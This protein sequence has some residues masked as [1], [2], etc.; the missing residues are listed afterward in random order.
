MRLAKDTVGSIRQECMLLHDGKKRSACLKSTRSCESLNR[1][2][3]MIELAQSESEV[4]VRQQDFDTNP[5]NFACNNG[6]IDLLSFEIYPPDPSQLISTI[7]HIAY[8]PD[9]ASQEWE[10][11]LAQSTEYDAALQ[12]FIQ[13]AV[14]Y[15]MFGSNEEEKLFFVYGPGASGKSTF[16][17]AIRMVFGDYA[18]MADFSSFLRQ[19][20][21]TG[22]RDDLAR[23]RGARLVIANE[24]YK[25]AKL[26]EA[27]IKM[28]TGGDTIMARA[29]YQDAQEWKPQFTLWL[30]AN[31]PPIADQEDDALWRRI[32]CLPFNRSVPEHERDPY[33]KRVLCDPKV[34]GAAI[35]NWALQG[36]LDYQE[37][38]LNPPDSVLLATEAYRKEGD[39]LEDWL[40]EACYESFGVF[41]GSAELYQSYESWALDHLLKPMSHKALSRALKKRGFTTTTKR[42]SGVHTRGFVGLELIN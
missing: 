10:D 4:V 21:S 32:L 15:S 36:C 35:L 37:K 18:K 42:V 13:R 31:D 20:T 33:L 22:P 25:G 6:S 7:S 41:S 40:A 27:T 2:K 34:S 16:V 23:L 1:L 19:R 5:N 28:L 39:Q 8:E 11:F 26:S 12:S 17:E 24:V 29:L 14:G 9:A 30:V 38:G 3:A